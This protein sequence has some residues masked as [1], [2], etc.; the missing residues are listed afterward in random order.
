MDK[1]YLC[2]AQSYRTEH[3][4]SLQRLEIIISDTKPK[5]KA[6][7]E[8]AELKVIDEADFDVNPLNHIMEMQRIGRSN[9]LFYMSSKSRRMVYLCKEGYATDD[10]VKKCYNELVIYCTKVIGNC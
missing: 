1:T 10:D 2:L 3:G 5:I 9:K 8:R 7:I 4:K 6:E